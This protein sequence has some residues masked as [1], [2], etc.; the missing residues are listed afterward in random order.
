MP[1]RARGVLFLPT[2]TLLAA[3]SLLP[4]TRPHS[5][6]YRDQRWKDRRLEI[7][8]RDEFSCI[9][10]GDGDCVLHV[11]HRYYVSGRMPW[12]YPDNALAT[13][14]ESCHAATKKSGHFLDFK[15]Q[16]RFLETT[17]PIA[18][19]LVLALREIKKHCHSEDDLIGT[20][21]W[22]QRNAELVI[23]AVMA[24]RRREGFA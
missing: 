7:L 13:L 15:S 24:D 3:V 14:C 18:N 11:H 12:E 9:A 17:E 21:G 4:M 23:R 8:E 16:E 5:D 1:L 2:F 20:V 10:C 22:L 6:R 19:Q